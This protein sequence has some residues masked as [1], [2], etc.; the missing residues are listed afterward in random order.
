MVFVS[1]GSA[2][3]LASPYSTLTVVPYT[4]K[5]ITKKSTNNLCSSPFTIH[6]NESSRLYHFHRHGNQRS[7][8]Q[9][10]SEGKIPEGKEG[11]R[12]GKESAA[13]GGWTVPLECHNPNPSHNPT[14]K[15]LQKKKGKSFCLYS[16]ASL[17]RRLFWEV[18]ETKKGEGEQSCSVFVSL[19]KTSFLPPRAARQDTNTIQQQPQQ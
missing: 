2:A 3:I 8:E 16:L 9:R 18:K 19:P 15:K 4:T 10:R 1:E 11:V 7:K 6:C 13:S 12:G 5:N 17:P 14:K